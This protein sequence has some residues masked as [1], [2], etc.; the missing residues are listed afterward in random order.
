MAYAYPVAPV[1]SDPTSVIGRRIGAFFIDAAIAMFAF[2]IIFIPLATQ[3]TVSETLQLPGC[4][5][6]FEDR[7]Q[8]ECNNRQIVQLGDTVYEADGGPTFGLDFVFVLLYFAI[9]PGLTGATAG[10]FATGIRVVDAEGRVANM[11]K[12]LVRW[13]V[14]AVDGPF[15]LFLCGLLTSLLS[16]GHRRLGD[17]AAGTYVVAKQ[18]VGQPIGIGGAPGAYGAAPMY[19]TPP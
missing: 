5:R 16:R 10:K 4:N 7:S 15:S 14:F 17:M 8:I 13:I 3:R 19:G 1:Q 18:A 6:K 2:A 9:L 12:S 11:G